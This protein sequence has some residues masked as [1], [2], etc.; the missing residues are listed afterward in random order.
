MHYY[1]IHERFGRDNITMGP[2][3]ASFHKNGPGNVDHVL[4]VTMSENGPRIGQI[5]LDGVYDRVGRD[6]EVK[7]LYNREREEN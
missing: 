5:T 6:L 3:G 4:W 7:E 1:D 2:A